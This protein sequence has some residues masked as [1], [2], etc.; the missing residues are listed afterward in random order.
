LL[1][2]RTEGA[3]YAWHGDQRA[4][5][6]AAWFLRE[7]KLDAGQQYE[8]FAKPD[9]RWEANEVSSRCGDIVELLAV[10]LERFAQ[11]AVRG[12]EMAAAPLPSELCDIWR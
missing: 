11:A 4:I 7:S 5:R 3:A 2:G 1:A 9:D 8:L 10:E 6:T 12:E